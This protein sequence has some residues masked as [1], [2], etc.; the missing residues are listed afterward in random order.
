[1][2]YLF[3]LIAGLTVVTLGNYFFN[4]YVAVCRLPIVY[5]VGELDERFGVTN[6]EAVEALV[7]AEA[8]WEEALGRDDIFI[9][10]ENGPFKINF[11]YDERQRQ[12]EAALSAENNLDV[13]GEANQVLTELYK[14][15]MLEYTEYE[16]E[17]KSKSEAYNT[18]LAEYN[19]EVEKYNNA[20]GATPKKYEELQNRQAEL[21]VE[22][23]ELNGIFSHLEDL[24][25]QINE[26]GEKGNELI[27]QY[28]ELVQ[29]F[30]HSF[31]H[32]HEYTQGDYRKKE[33]NVYSFTSE[34]DLVLVLAHELGH[35]LA[36]GHVDDPHAIMYYLMKDQTRPP[37]LLESDKAAF[38]SICE[39]S[40]V[41]K[42]LSPWLTIYNVLV[43]N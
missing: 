36:I 39:A 12:A 32:G 22:R 10:E 4:P 27:G 18:K 35:A 1:M 13:R 24:H 31:A 21:E 8:V 26:I 16:K 11:I 34:E 17:Y 41:H 33:I 37:T 30:N 28:N 7:K 40:L 42:L 3:L 29:D 23:Q 6:A 19:A 5:S 14:R 9:H 20:G 43:N 25:K 2:R 38:H 15:L